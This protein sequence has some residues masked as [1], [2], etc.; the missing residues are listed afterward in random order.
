MASESKES[1][2]MDIDTL[3]DKVSKLPIPDTQKAH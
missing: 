3:I 2:N 1:N